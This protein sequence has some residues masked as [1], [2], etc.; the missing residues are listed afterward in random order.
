MRVREGWWGALIVASSIVG[1]PPLAAQQKRADVELE[2]APTFKLENPGQRDATLLLSSPGGDVV[3]RLMGEVEGTRVTLDVKQPLI[4]GHIAS[5]NVWIVVHGW[6]ARGDIG[7][8]PVFFTVAP[9]KDGEIVR[10]EMPGHGVRLELEPDKL[11]WLPGCERDLPGVP[12]PVPTFEGGCVRDTWARVE[13]PQQILDLPSVP[14]M[15][16]LAILLTDRD[17]IFDGYPPWIFGPR[18]R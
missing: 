3:L 15:V 18:A 11:S 4:T 1:A 5:L 9:T 6:E 13:V 10:G 17:P 8:Y 2:P 7:G 14:R 16:L 12:G